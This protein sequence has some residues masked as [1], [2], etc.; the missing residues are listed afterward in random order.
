M[1]EGLPEKY[2]AL[3][4]NVKIYGDKMSPEEA[5][6]H[7]LEHYR[8][9]EQRMNAFS[10]NNF[11][12]YNAHHF[13]SNFNGGK[14]SKNV[15]NSG[16][17]VKKGRSSEGI[18]KRGKGKGVHAKNHFDHDQ[19]KVCNEKGH[20]KK[21][22][23]MH[24]WSVLQRSPRTVMMT[25]MTKVLALV[26]APEKGSSTTVVNYK[27]EQGGQC[28]RW[29]SAVTYFPLF[30]KPKSANV[31]LFDSCCNA[32]ITCFKERIFNYRQFP[33]TQIVSVFGG[34]AVE[35][36]G[37]GQAVL[38]DEFGR[39]YALKHIFIFLKSAATN[40][41][42]DEVISAGWTINLQRHQVYFSVAGWLHVV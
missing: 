20:W 5:K 19:C 3:K 26:L 32:N 14:S 38:V 36:E 39:S 40:A 33:K 35:V 34:L 29:F 11:K 28:S 7:I 42:N 22:C 2:G 41:Y 24:L 21:A 8:L 31:S 4:A 16:H 30:F 37:E 25:I 17:R 12:A 1:F 18:L 15:N 6:N 9:T 10:T 13:N 23:L 27:W